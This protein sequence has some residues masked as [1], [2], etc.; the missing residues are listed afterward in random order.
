MS[1]LAVAVQHFQATSSPWGNGTW[2][3]VSKHSP[4]GIPSFF[5][6]FF[7]VRAA[8]AAT[9][10][11]PPLANGTARGQCPP[12]LPPLAQPVHIPM[13]SRGH[14]GRGRN[15]CIPPS[16]PRWG[17]WSCITGAKH[18]TVD[19]LGGH[20][21]GWLI[22]TWITI[23][24]LEMAIREGLFAPS[25]SEAASALRETQ[26]GNLDSLFLPTS[27]CSSRLVSCRQIVTTS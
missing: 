2:N 5:P 15:P 17:P 6:S 13:P 3:G 4:G 11:P 12:L 24:K 22:F 8:L 18:L 27:S 9:P 23:E 25:S 16:P 14:L 21:L 20:C 19:L 26:P 10:R 1:L 7:L